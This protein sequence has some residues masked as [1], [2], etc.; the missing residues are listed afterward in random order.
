MKK[1]SRSILFLLALITLSSFWN[2]A[3]QPSRS[4][5]V[6]NGKEYGKVPGAFFRDRWW[7]YYQRG[8]SFA[9]GEF[10]QEALA[11]F[12]EAIERREKDQWMAR[13]YGMHFIDYFPHR[14]L[15]I[16]YYQ[17]GNLEAAKKELELSLSHSPSAKA[18]FYLDHVRK[19]LIERE[20]KEVTPPELTLNFETAEVWTREDPVVLSGVAADEA[21]V[22]GISINSVPIFLDGSEK[23][24]SFRRELVLSHGLHNIQVV[25][26]NLLRRTTK[27]QIVIHVDREGPLVILEELS[28]NRSAKGREV[29]IGGLINDEAGVSELIINGQVIPIRKGMEVSFSYKLLI[30]T[31][32]LALVA[33]DRLGNQTSS[34]F[35]LSP[36]SVSYVPIQLAYAELGGGAPLTRFLFGTGDSLP[37]RIKLKGWTDAQTVYLEK[38]YLEGQIIDESKI[39]S[40]TVNQIPIVLSPE[41]RIIFFSHFAELREGE[42]TIKIEARDKAGNTATREISVTRK[43][44]KALQ[45]A[46]RLRL[47]V[48][49][50][51]AKGEISDA[52]LSFQNNLIESLVEQNRFWV[53]E[54]DKLDV[55]LE[56]QKLSQSK[57]IERKT[58]LRL[59]EL[60]AAQSIIV[61]SIFETRMGIEVVSRMIDTETAEILATEDVYGEV[62]DIPA[63]R[64]LAEGMAIKFHRDF[65]LVDGLVIQKERRNIFTDLGQGEIKARRRLIVYREKPIRHPVTEM[66]LGADNEIIGHARVSQV[67]AEMSKAEVISGET[68]SI[69][70]MDKVL[71]E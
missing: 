14:E 34:E 24:I 44:P 2:C 25:A 68:E 22:A 17:T 26:R 71:T 35:R 33:R 42:N 16:L 57:L 5:Y 49:P 6:K 31:D 1:I 69:K 45:L 10:Y 9:E 55:I 30:D 43:V 48:L 19:T 63:L 66:V 27:K 52:S 60:V 56:E 47:T 32:V 28:L 15:G 4:V 50:F 61:G 53:V 40:L 36:E 23:R 3:P 54:R 37:P 21:Y 13:T 8:L 58:A 11:D 18:R 70:P 7:N 41:G 67:M 20:A 12:K 38:I 59:G 29:T 65:P 62:K 64:S 51:E 46:E 39:E